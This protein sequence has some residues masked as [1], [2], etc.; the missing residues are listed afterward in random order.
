M[1][2]SSYVPP[3]INTNKCKDENKTCPAKVIPEKK[4]E[5]SETQISMYVNIVRNS[6]KKTHV[7]TRNVNELGGAPG[8]P[9]G[10]RAPP[11][12]KF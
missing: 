4:R 2:Y 10:S 11:R 3:R 1:S 9:G 7:Y 12:N 6:R 8:A 5:W